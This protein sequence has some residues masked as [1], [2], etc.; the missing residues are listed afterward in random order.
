MILITLEYFSVEFLMKSYFLLEKYRLGSIHLDNLIQVDNNILDWASTTSSVVYWV[1]TINHS[2]RL[3]ASDVNSPDQF[4]QSLTKFFEGRVIPFCCR[5][6]GEASDSVVDPFFVQHCCAKLATLH[7]D[8][9]A[10]SPL[11]A[12]TSSSLGIYSLMVVRRFRMA[13]AMIVAKENA[14]L[15]I[16]RLVVQFIRH[17]KSAPNS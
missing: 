11:E 7:Q 10:L 9:L 6:F 12:T 13:L 4:E 1:T 17:T 16:K 3:Y 8:G 14:L 5:A 2:G 15:K